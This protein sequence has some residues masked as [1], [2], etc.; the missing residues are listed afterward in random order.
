MT[1]RPLRQLGRRFLSQQGQANSRDFDLIVALMKRELKRDSDCLD[2]GANEGQFLTEMTR[3]A[4][5]GEHVAWEPLPE[6][7]M[8]LRDSFPEA[9]IREAALSDR[10]GYGELQV[11]VD[12]PGWSGLRARPTAGANR[13]KA[14][15]V[16]YER[17]DDALPPTVTP[18]LIVL[19][20]EGAEELVLRG[21]MD[22]IRQYRPTIVFE[23]GVDAA[24]LY[25]SS[26]ASIHGLLTDVLGYGVQ[27]L[28]GT[29]PLD[30]AE[31]ARVVAGGERH[32]FVARPV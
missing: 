22:A 11:S 23:H 32:K 16:R 3:I 29:G 31:L 4:S 30:A 21:G 17:L 12:D 1:M 7:A 8:K 10:N 18:R 9:H 14:L 25:D 20:V 13:Y 19:G 15:I 6:F 27:G 26:A 24:G 2:I 28:D 5:R